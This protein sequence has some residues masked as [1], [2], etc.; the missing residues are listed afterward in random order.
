VSARSTSVSAR[1]ASA[2]LDGRQPR[3]LTAEK[4]IEHSRLSL[5]W[6][7]QRIVLGFG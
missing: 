1:S 7:D 6:H 3:D 5:A 2:I 4:L